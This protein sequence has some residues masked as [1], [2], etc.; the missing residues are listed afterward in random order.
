MTGNKENKQSWK[1]ISAA[2]QGS[3][4][5][6]CKTQTEYGSLAAHTGEGTIDLDLKTVEAE[7]LAKEGKHY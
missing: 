3:I 1:S 6:E 4:S 2:H 7:L 5:A